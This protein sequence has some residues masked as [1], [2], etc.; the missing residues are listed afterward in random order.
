MTATTTFSRRTVMAGAAATFAAPGIVRAQGQTL[1]VGS[2]LPR[3]GFFAQA[4][5]SMHRGVLAAP[6]LLKELG[7]KVEIVHIDTESN[8]D[9][10]RTQAER[11]IN[12]GCHVLTGAFDSGHTLAIAQV[13]EQRQIP[14]VVNVAAAPQI[15][16]QGYKYL[17][18]NFQTGGQLVT[19]GLRLIKDVMDAKGIK[20]EKAVFL[21]ANDTFGTAQR[22][23]M[24]AIWPRVN[25]PIELVEKIAYDPRAQDLSVEVTKIRSLNPDLVM[26]VTRA[27]DAIK[28][29]RDMVRQR[30]QPKAIISPGS[31]GFYDEE[32]YQALGPLADFVMF[33]L[34]WA[35]PK[36]NMTQAF[37]KSFA[38]ANPNNRFAVDSFNAGFAFEGML[39]AADA[40]KR[41]GTTNGPAL[42]EAVRATNLPEHIMI[43]GPITFDA[44]GQNPNIG[45]ALV[46][47]L[48][49]VPTVVL[50]KDVAVAEP[51][52]PL[53]AWQG[54]S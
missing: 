48:K 5:Q 43:G 50:P 9:V 16:E 3:S 38:K 15:T 40:F 1:K 28:M 31:P 22:G 51:V 32:F 37:E 35:N 52:L 26:C 36:S 13:T 7:Y 41:A 42:M 19:N 20:F 53:P 44:K 49:R 27:S 47:N 4:G 2:L 45:S 46:Q 10:A 21:H 34:P 12:D 30:F 14:F 24:D 33:G 18:R 6:E 39:I 17:V 23:A 11:A 25:L 54:R 8:A 29:V